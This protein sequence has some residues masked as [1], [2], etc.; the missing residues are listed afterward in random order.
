MPSPLIRAEIDLSAIDHNIKEIRRITGPDVMILAPVKAN[1]YG[2]GALRVS[3]QVIASGASMLGVARIN[4][5]IELRKAGILV[6]VLILGNTP[7]EFAAELMAH[8]LTAAVSSRETAEKYAQAARMQK[9]E[10]R[11]HLKIDSGMGR[12][13]L[14]SDCF[15]I[16]GKGDGSGVLAEIES[17]CRLTGLRVEG[18]FS[19]FAIADAADK[20]SANRQFEIFSDLLRQMEKAGIEIP[21]RHIANSAATIDM[22]HTHLDMVRPGI[23]VYGL[24]PSDEIRLDRID[25]KPAMAVKA[26]IAHLKNVGAG[27]KISYGSTYAT[28]APTRIAVVP[29]GYADGYSRRLSSRGRMLVHGQRAPIVGRI[30]MDL[31]MIDVG[32]IPGVKPGDEVVILG[33]QGT[34]KLSADEI[35]A[36]LGTINYEI[37]STIAH[38]VPRVYLT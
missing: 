22:P 32:H 34:E 30:C 9:G 24:N 27:F 33:S 4:E 36:E 3:R 11:V 31:T 23:A 37:V 12:N 5:G 17:I 14:L 15:R 18:V 26:R 20:A 35:A 8:D 25:L 7:S 1:A 13:G 29:V 21:I 6:P 38:R 16:S 19:H 28:P 10:I 2:H